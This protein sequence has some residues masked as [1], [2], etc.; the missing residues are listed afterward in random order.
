MALDG[1]EVDVDDD[2]KEAHEDNTNITTMDKQER[3]FHNS[4]GHPSLPTALIF[5]AALEPS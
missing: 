3:Y 2:R 1:D 5:L 4:L